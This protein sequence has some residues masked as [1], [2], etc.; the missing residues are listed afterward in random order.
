MLVD[1]AERALSESP[2][3]EA[4]SALLAGED[5]VDLAWTVHVDD[6]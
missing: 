3:L 5:G 4:R 2:L 1:M 6:E